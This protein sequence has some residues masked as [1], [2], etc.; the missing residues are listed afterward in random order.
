[1]RVTTEHEEMKNHRFKQLLW[2][3]FLYAS[4][5]TVVLMVAMSL[6]MLIMPIR[7]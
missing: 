3:A 1:M 6:H 5:V 2:F 7:N 4:G